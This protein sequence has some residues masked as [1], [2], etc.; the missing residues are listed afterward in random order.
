MMKSIKFFKNDRKTQFLTCVILVFLIS[1]MFFFLNYPGKRY[2]FY[3]TVSGS[4][5]TVHEFR[6]VKK[7]SGK[8]EIEL[9]VEELLLGTFL[10]RAVS[11]FPLGT[12]ILFCFEKDDVLYLNLSEDAIFN[13]DEKTTLD[14]RVELLSLNVRKNFP[15]LKEIEL[16][17]DGNP[18]VPAEK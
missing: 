12:R 3:F 2:S 4:Q 1:L 8:P 15:K 11:V 6:P 10:E 7:I 5:K 9:Y 14:S 13:L 18:V 16:Y 17:I